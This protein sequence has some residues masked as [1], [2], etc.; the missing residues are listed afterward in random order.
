LFT[1]ILIFFGS[2]L[3]SFLGSVQLGP[4]N[5]FVINTALFT[6]KREA[7][8]I[9]IGGILPEFIYCSLAVFATSYILQFDWII[10]VFEITFIA[11]FVVIAILF[12]IKKPINVSLNKNEISK[13]SNFLLVSKGFMLA[14]LN[15]QL[16]PFW[17][18]VQVYFNQISFLNVKTMLDKT[19]YVLGA[20]IGAFVLLNFFIYFSHKHREKVL[21]YVNNSYYFKVL[22]V[23]F[24]TVAV[25]QLWKYFN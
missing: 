7:L 12:F 4:V 20:G 22:S 8:L 6:G 23:L 19:S 14:I 18:F 15:P 24:F 11:V 25:Y 9:A 17:V 10:P 5:I 13:Q 3:V 21:S 16:L 1:F 2:T